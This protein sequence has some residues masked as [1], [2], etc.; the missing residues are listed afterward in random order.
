MEE[1]IICDCDC[2]QK[3]CSILHCMPCC[4]LTNSS[5]INSDGTIDKEEF[6][7]AFKQVTGFPPTLSTKNGKPAYLHRIPG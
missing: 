3:G 4:S 1:I 7:K 6:G 2:H 5:Y